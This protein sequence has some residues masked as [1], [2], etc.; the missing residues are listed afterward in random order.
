MTARKNEQRRMNTEES[1]LKEVKYI[2][3]VSSCKG[4][5]VN[6]RLPHF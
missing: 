6:P 1:G 4:G 3:A 5:L 2:L